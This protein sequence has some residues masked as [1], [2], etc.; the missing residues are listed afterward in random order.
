VESEIELVRMYGAETLAV[1]LN[2]EIGEMEQII[3]YQKDLATRLNLPV[4]RPIQE[5][6][7]DLLPLI[8]GF[9][10]EHD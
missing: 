9:I 8:K 3:A 6:V 10:A 4:V 2:T 5:G 7:D 1:V